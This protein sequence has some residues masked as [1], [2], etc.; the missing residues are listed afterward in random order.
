MVCVYGSVTWVDHD[1]CSD[2]VVLIV[3]VS[4]YTDWSVDWPGEDRMVAAKVHNVGEHWACCVC[5]G[6]GVE[7]AHCGSIVII[8]VHYVC[9]YVSVRTAVMFECPG[10]GSL[11][12]FFGLVSVVPEACL[13]SDSDSVVVVLGTDCCVTSVVNFVTC[14]ECV[15]CGSYSASLVL[16]A[17]CSKMG[18][19]LTLLDCSVYRGLCMIDGV[20]R[21]VSVV[22]SGTGVEVSV[23]VNGLSVDGDLL[24]LTAV[25]AVVLWDV[26]VWSDV[27][28][29]A[30]CVGDLLRVTVWCSCACSVDSS[31]ANGS[32]CGL[33]SRFG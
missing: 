29:H 15:L 25:L 1:G 33:A 23:V 20:V 31:L 18:S 17:E 14:G 24:V 28:I 4:E 30:A 9:S 3:V 6:V 19:V 10:A 7:V 5:D 26:M 2:S 16:V 21:L 22:V 32:D 11:V 13:D 27:D 8:S 12:A